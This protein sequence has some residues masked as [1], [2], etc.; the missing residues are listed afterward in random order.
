VRGAQ[1]PTFIDRRP[2][3]NQR[4]IFLKVLGASAVTTACGSS[5]D[6]TTTSASTSVS[7]ASTAGAGG[8]GGDSTVATDASTS[9]DA[10]SATGSGGAGR[11]LPANYAAVGNVSDIMTGLLKPVSAASVLLGRDANGV[12][13]MTSLCTHNFCDMCVKG[14]V[15]A[16]GIVCTCH[17]SKFDP[18]GKVTQGPALKPLD[19]YDCVVLDD[20]TIGVDKAKVV[21]ADFRAPVP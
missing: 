15:S 8:A 4:R 9:A 12:Y 6:D 16:A 2:F 18:N 14:T 17:N 1:A 3:V 10:S 11:G 20:G 13:A 7:S 19:H 21:A 5:D